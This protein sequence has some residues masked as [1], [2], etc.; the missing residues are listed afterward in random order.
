VLKRVG[1][2][3][4][5]YSDNGNLTEALKP[6]ERYMSISCVSMDPTELYPPAL[7][8]LCLNGGGKSCWRPK[9]P[10]YLNLLR[11]REKADPHGPPWKCDE[12]ALSMYPRKDLSAVTAKKD[13]VEQFNQI[14]KAKELADAIGL[15]FN[16]KASEAS[17]MLANRVENISEKASLHAAAADLRKQMITVEQLYKDG[18]GEL[19]NN[20]P[21]KANEPFTE[22]LQLDEKLVLGPI[23]SALPP[24]QRKKELEKLTSYYRQNIQQDMASAAYV[25]GKD[26]MDRQDRRQACR[27]WKLGFSYWKGN[28]DLLRAVSNICTGEA[29]ARLE[30]A[31]SCE[32]L[33]VVLEFAVDGDGHKEKVEK[34]KADLGCQP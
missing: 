27:M 13:R 10:M 20:R 19:G 7:K 26:L 29:Q 9:D 28:V 18:Q 11:A 23:K 22:A 12:V 4:K 21:D 31:A 34:K 17:A 5:R 14:Y 32:D 1:P 15:Y 3:C 6:C 24:E 33:T 30:A 25:R 8:Q 2:E 16:G